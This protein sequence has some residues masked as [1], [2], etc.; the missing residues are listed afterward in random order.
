MHHTVLFTVLKKPEGGCREG[1]GD[2]PRVRPRSGAH[3]GGP[4]HPPAKEQYPQH[5][6]TRQGRHD[7][8]HCRRAPAEA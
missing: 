7:L 1:S 6:Q 4:A 2:L 5:L 8:H 3:G